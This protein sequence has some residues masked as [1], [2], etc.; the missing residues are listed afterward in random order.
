MQV[1][2][3]L[4]LVAN[5]EKL[6]GKLSGIGPALILLGLV[7]VN[8]VHDDIR[9]DNVVFFEAVECMRVEKEDVGVYDIGLLLVFRMTGS[10]SCLRDSRL[11][12]LEIHQHVRAGAP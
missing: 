9:D 4:R 1:F 12:L 2:S 7:I 6:A 5:L 8:F 11:L 10:R 3:R